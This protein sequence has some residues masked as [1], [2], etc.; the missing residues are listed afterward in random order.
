MYTYPLPKRIMQA[1]GLLTI[2]HEF[3]SNYRQVFIDGR[4][5]PVDPNPSW[6]GYSSG[7]WD[8]DTLV[9]RTIGFRDGLWADTRGN[10]LTDAATIT[11]RIRRPN[12]GTLMVE[13][14]V[15][16]PKAYTAPWTVTITQ[17][18]KAD[19]DLL[20]YICMENEKDLEHLPAR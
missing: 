2:V 6:L 1:P 20:E 3:N 11:E 5:L 7:V 16:D 10:P 18:L 13:V 14:T 15:D 17:G 19:T 9:V 8:A 12:F 4:P